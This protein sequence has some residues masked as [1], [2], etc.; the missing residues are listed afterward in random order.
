M[1][2]RYEIRYSILP[3]VCPLFLDLHKS[4]GKSD[5]CSWYS[6]IPQMG[7]YQVGAPALWVMGIVG[8]SW[9]ILGVSWGHPSSTTSIK[10]S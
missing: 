10:S 3:L 8:V 5:V 9:G 7:E 4:Q 2:T 6:P 1:G